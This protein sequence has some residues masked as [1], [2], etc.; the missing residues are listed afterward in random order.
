MIKKYATELP[1]RGN[2]VPEHPGR[3]QE[4]PAA[5]TT[6]P[7]SPQDLSNNTACRLIPY[8]FCLV[9]VFWAEDPLTRKLETQTKG[10]RM[11][12]QVE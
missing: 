10:Y 8:P 1:R 6:Y 4:A 5:A 2:R 3:Y 11:S 7:L 12:L 9:T